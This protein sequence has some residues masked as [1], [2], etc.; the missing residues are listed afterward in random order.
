MKTLMEKEACES[1][2][3]VERQLIE[4][5]AIIQKI[6]S[7]IHEKKPLFAMT[8]GRGSSDNACNYAKYLIETKL[9]LVTA[10]AAPS[11]VTIYKRPLNLK[12]VLV[13]GISQSGQS[14]DI[15]GMMEYARKQGAIT[16][17]II[18]E[19]NSPMGRMAEFVIP[20]LAGE[21]KAVAATKTFIASLSAVVQL[22]AV[23][24]GNLLLM[25][26]IS[27]LPAE[28]EKA[29][30]CDWSAIVSL[31]K[32]VVQTYVIARGFSYPIAQEAALKFKETASIHAEAFSSAD[33][34]HGPLTLVKPNH[35]FLLFAQQD[36]MLP[37]LIETVKKIKRMGGYPI[38]GAS[39][40]MLKHYPDLY[41]DLSV[42]LSI[43]NSIHPIL[44]PIVSIQAFYPMMAKLAVSLGKN[45]DAPE[46]LKKVTETQ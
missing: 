23:T 2:R 8:I 38:M 14:P 28:L 3:V 39:E 46:H 24:S 13:I 11:V 22:V 32:H 16:V 6:A 44:D 10:S 21:E 35:P 7:V 19:V 33:L 26:A 30:H 29:A 4:N 43:P 36:E 31:Y 15:C 27:K 42:T 20:M 5:Q 41:D 12:N 9:N 37:L 18:N 34:M 45:P 40:W 25:E 17:A 1:P